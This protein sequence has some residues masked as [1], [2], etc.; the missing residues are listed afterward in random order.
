MIQGYN[1]IDGFNQQ[2]CCGIFVTVAVL[3]TTSFN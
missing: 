2:I 3:P 1:V